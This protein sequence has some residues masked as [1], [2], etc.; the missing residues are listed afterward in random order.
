MRVKFLFVLL[1]VHSG[2]LA[3]LEAQGDPV[4]FLL[5]QGQDGL[6]HEGVGEDA[7]LVEGFL[8]AAWASPEGWPPP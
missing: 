2:Q 4:L 8:Q 3:A 7:A 6:A 1:H 5:V